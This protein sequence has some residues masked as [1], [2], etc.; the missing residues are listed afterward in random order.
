MTEIELAFFNN[1]KC[2]FIN[3]FQREVK[4]QFNFS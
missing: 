3:L 2:F 4:K 1:W